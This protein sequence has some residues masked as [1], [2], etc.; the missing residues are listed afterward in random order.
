MMETIQQIDEYTNTEI[1]WRKE[2]A[3]K[4]EENGWIV[5][6]AV[7]GLILTPIFIGLIIILADALWYWQRH[8]QAARLRNEIF[9]LEMT[10]R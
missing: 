2:K 6:V 10:K 7:I 1:A 9:Q 5:I 8:S 4:L 3:Q